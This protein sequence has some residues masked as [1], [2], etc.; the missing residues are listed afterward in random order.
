MA[1]IQYESHNNA[2]NF[3]KKKETHRNEEKEFLPAYYSW[4]G[5]MTLSIEGNIAEINS[6]VQAY[7][8]P[9][10]KTNFL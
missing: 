7:W 6:Q 5:C 1:Y 4:T 8:R 3:A 9:E 2:S 10:L